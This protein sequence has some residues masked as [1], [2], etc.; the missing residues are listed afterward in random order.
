M[1]KIIYLVVLLAFTASCKSGKLHKKGIKVETTETNADKDFL[2]INQLQ[3][4]EIDFRQAKIKS[5]IVADFKSF[6]QKFPITVQLQKNEIIWASVTIGF[7]L[8]RLQ[9]TPDE[10]IILD[11][12]NRTAYSGTWDDL[13]DVTGFRLNFDMFQ[14]LVLGNLFFP[15]QE[16]D[17][18]RNDDSYLSLLQQREGLN[19]ENRIDYK[20]KKLVEIIGT[21]PSRGTDADL[22]YDSFVSVDDQIVPTIVN[23]VLSGRN[24][25]KLEIKHSAFEFYDSGLNFSFSV[26]SNYKIK[27]IKDL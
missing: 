12:F 21:D 4:N 8:A 11:R 23:F 22:K 24:N 27:R 13:S 17:Q 10:L 18:L 16:G 2:S 19:F 15:A 20:L 7:E 26:P 14:A 25:G 3:L 9:F 1:R 5:N 6:S